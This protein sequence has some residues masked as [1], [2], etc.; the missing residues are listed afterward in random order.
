MGG[1]FHG[2]LLVITRG[3][4]R[5]IYEVKPTKHNGQIWSDNVA[6]YQALAEEKLVS[7]HSAHPPNMLN[8]WAALGTQSDWGLEDKHTY[9]V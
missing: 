6:F 8:T 4:K 2:K 5:Q 1:S 3:Y 7:G 9:A